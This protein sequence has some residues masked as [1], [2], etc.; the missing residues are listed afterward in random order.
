MTFVWLL[1]CASLSA[2]ASPMRRGGRS[3]QRSSRLSDFSANKRSRIITRNGAPLLARGGLKDGAPRGT[4]G[5]PPWSEARRRQYVEA[6]ASPGICL[7]CSR[8][9]ALAIAVEGLQKAGLGSVRRLIDLREGIFFDEEG[10]L[11]R[12][13]V[14]PEADTMVTRVV[15]AALIGEADR[16]SEGLHLLERRCPI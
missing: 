5:E 8:N 6:T 4:S 7:A 11:A 2:P 9:D 12:I 3:P 1:V 13:V 14:T 15:A 10:H 16:H